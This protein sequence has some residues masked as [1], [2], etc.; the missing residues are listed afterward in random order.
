MKRNT[1]LSVILLLLL[2]PAA[3]APPLE[4]ATVI[5]VID[6]DTIV[7][8][9][10]EY[11]RYIGIDAPDVLPRNEAYGFQ[12]LQLNRELVEGKEVTLEKD[13]LYK[14]EDGRLLRYVYAGNLFVNG[15]MVRR[16][17][18]EAV[19][20]PPNLENQKHL[21]GLEAVARESRR[22]MWGE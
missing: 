6:G 17:L 13:K 15:E 21:E 22:G 1:I 7:I 11:V 3:C 4:T 2:A 14:D 18:A 5:E 12:S 9:S 10:G 8:D 16:G 20:Y 19:A